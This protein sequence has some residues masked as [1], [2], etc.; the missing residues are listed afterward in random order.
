MLSAVLLEIVAKE[1]CS[2]SEVSHTTHEVRSLIENLA[3]EH[4]L[5]EI[6]TTLVDDGEHSTNVL[7]ERLA[8]WIDEGMAR[9]SGWYKRQA[10]VLIFLIAGTVTVAT[11]ASTIHIAEEF[12]QNDALR[13]HIATRA[14]MAYY[15]ADHSRLQ[16]KDLERLEVFP[17]GWMESP[18]G[19]L[20]W[21]K[22]LLGWVLT[23]AAVSLGA[24]FWFDLLNRVANLRASGDQV[25][26]QQSS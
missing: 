3:H 19:I 13:T 26:T 6:L 4:P 9:I 11:N 7:K 20:D 8:N 14:Q 16:E 10:K 1:N 5:K 24:P 23:T 18:K 22:T 2:K 25:Q 12:W 21:L 17:I 15:N